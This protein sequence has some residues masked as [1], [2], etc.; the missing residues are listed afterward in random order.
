M[1]LDF[2]D[3]FSGC[4]GT[5]RGMQDAGMTVRF[6][7]DVDPDAKMTYEAN[8]KKAKFI[9]KDIRLVSTDDVAPYIKRRYG[10]PLLFGACAPCQ[11]FSKQNRTK[12]DGRWEKE[13]VG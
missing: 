10:R 9:Y 2:Y 8:Y 1:A 13:F 12:S 5:S 6:G 7:L 4:G 11:P 3:F